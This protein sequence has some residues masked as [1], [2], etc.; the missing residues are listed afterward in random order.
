MPSEGKEE[1]Q[2]SREELM[3]HVKDT[4][5]A[6]LP[7]D[8]F[9]EFCLWLKA[10]RF[11]E[12]FKAYAGHYLEDGRSAVLLRV[13]SMRLRADLIDRW[14][15]EILSGDINNVPHEEFDEVESGMLEMHAHSEFEGLKNNTPED[16]S[17]EDC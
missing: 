14:Y 3:M 8:K 9:R 4:L 6:I 15:A 13:L 11:G 12:D 1:T 7:K 5:L 2:I 10:Y 17:G 16:E